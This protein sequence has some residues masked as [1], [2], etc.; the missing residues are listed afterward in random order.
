MSPDLSRTVPNRL[1]VVRTVALTRTRTAATA[2][3][4]AAV[5]RH[6]EASP[7]PS[8]ETG[9]AVAIKEARLTRP[10]TF[11]PVDCRR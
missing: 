4:P 8:A 5:T 10:I 2:D 3:R 7:A 11:S 6:A 1:G 9:E